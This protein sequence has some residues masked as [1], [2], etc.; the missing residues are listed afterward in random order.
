MDAD[1]KGSCLLGQPGTKGHK[2]LC[3]IRHGQGVH[4]PKLNPVDLMY[5][6]G[7][8]Q[9]D[10]H[11]TDKGRRQARALRSLMQS[12]PFEVVLVSPLTRTIETASEIF[13]DS[14]VPK[15][16][17]SLMCERC[18]MPAD[19]GTP[20]SQLKAKHPQI[21]SW[22]GFDDLAEEFWP[23]RSMWNGDAEVAERAADFKQWLL[24]RNETCIALVGHSAF[25][26]AMTGKPKLRNCEVNLHICHE[27]RQG[28]PQL[29]AFHI[30][31]MVQ[32]I[33]QSKHD[34]ASRAC[35]PFPL[36]YF[37]QATSCARP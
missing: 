14:E 34:K 28:H 27:P 7:M 13:G 25:F 5:L 35:H 1:R 6:V 26:S 12:L 16:L 36:Q 4:N 24:C 15:H 20:A 37:H 9:R 33:E 19:E 21:E 11:L 8:M 10:A 31:A 22:D 3:L 23:R 2:I 29:V 32:H 17:V 30:L 18:M